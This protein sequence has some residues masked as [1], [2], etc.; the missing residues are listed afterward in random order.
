MMSEWRSNYKPKHPGLSLTD[1]IA[2]DMRRH[3]PVEACHHD[4]LI[5]EAQNYQWCE[6][7][8]AFRYWLALCH[9]GGD[10]T[11]PRAVRVETKEREAE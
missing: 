2:E 5:D 9:K 7:C 1:R 6:D 4:I 11:L 3:A 10:W 8:V